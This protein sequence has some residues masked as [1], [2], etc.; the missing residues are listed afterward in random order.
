[1]RFDDDELTESHVVFVA[2]LI[3][4]TTCELTARSVADDGAVGTAE[5][6][7]GPVG[8]VPDFVPELEVPISDLDQT[9]PGWTLFNLTNTA[10]QTNEV[11]VMVD[12]QGRYRWYHRRDGDTRASGGFDTRAVSEGVMTSGRRGAM[13]APAIINYEGHIVWEDRFNTHHDMR[14]SPFD[15]DNLLYLSYADC[16]AAG[17]NNEAIAAEWDRSAGE[18]IWEWNICEHFT[19][20][21]ITRNWSHLNSIEGF[22]G[23]R[24]VLLSSRDTN[25]LFKVDRDSD[26][27]IW[28]LGEGGDFD[29][30]AED[31][32]LHQHA[33]EI[34]PDGNILL[35]DNGLASRRAYSRAIE[36]ELVFDVLGDPVRFDAVWEYADEARF[37]PVRG[38]A[39][40]LANGNTLITY[41]GVNPDRESIFTEVTP[42]GDV[43]WELHTP[44][45]WGAYRSDRVVDIY[46]GE[47]LHE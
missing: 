42:G 45:N 39:D 47:V 23:E 34:Q 14:P 46:L 21:R 32:F 27:I 6:T 30:D 11:I 19:P 17:A 1:M 18:A 28:I 43:V 4:G 13:P 8:P 35:Y 7:F 9:Q 12:L 41:G 22:P 33:P 16:G 37:T 36:Y 26:E 2:G 20:T 29:F 3:E 10:N 25:K 44:A 15:D 31:L 38:D 40:R 5:A 24:T